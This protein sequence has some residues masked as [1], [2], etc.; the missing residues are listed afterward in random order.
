M[1]VSLSHSFVALSLAA[2]PLLGIAQITPPQ[3]VTEARTMARPDPK[4]LT[5]SG[6]ASANV[7]AYGADASPMSSL[8]NGGNGN[9][10]M[11]GMDRVTNCSTQSDVECQSVQLIRNGKATRPT[12][13]VAPSDPLISAADAIRRNPAPFHGANPFGGVTPPNTQC[14]TS[15]TSTPGTFTDETCDIATPAHEQSCSVVR[16]IVVDRDANYRC[17]TVGNQ[18]QTYVCDKIR[19]VTVTWTKACKIDSFSQVTP[20]LGTMVAGAS[21]GADLEAHFSFKVAPAFEC[22]AGSCNSSYYTLDIPLRKASPLSGSIKLAANYRCGGLPCYITM[23]WSWDGIDRVVV[24]DGGDASFRLAPTY[25]GS[26]FLL[27]GVCS[28]GGTY[29]IPYAYPSFC[30]TCPLSPQ[31]GCYVP[32]SGVCPPGFSQVSIFGSGGE[33]IGDTCYRAPDRY[34]SQFQVVGGA[35]NVPNVTEDWTNNCAALEARR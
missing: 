8:F 31:P 23:N 4:A 27:P 32:L 9:L 34:S 13:T 17:I 11:P 29:Q 16:D 21:C 26:G 28:A 22:H 7:P 25:S 1:A 12:F 20:D 19:N 3:A 5:S 33:P 15:T 24:D 35:Y 18:L 30:D 14:T 2:L 10:T 6:S